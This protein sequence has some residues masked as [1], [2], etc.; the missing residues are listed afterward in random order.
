MNS[1]TQNMNSSNHINMI[2]QFLKDF[3]NDNLQS[4]QL[5]LAAMNTEVN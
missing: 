5:K 3:L 4:L 2:N 1:V